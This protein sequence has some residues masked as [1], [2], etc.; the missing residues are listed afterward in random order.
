[1]FTLQLLHFSDAEAGLLAGA[2]GPVAR[3]GTAANLA[4]LVD[5]FEDTYANTLVLAGGDNYLP[6]P[7]LSAGTDPT[8]GAVHSR[9]TNP[10]A[11]DIEIHNR[12]GVDAST[13]GNHEFDLGTNV[14]SDA[15]NDALFP[16]LSANLD[17]S[18]D[19]ALRTRYLETVGTGGLEDV[20]GLARRI[21]PSAVVNQGGETIGLVGATT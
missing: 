2:P 12:I 14:F 3:Y 10:G 15:I 4:A 13:I 21:V 8:V 20:T 9:G 18:G 11:A 19:S 5:A 1:M 16:Y 7:F 17:F 6:G